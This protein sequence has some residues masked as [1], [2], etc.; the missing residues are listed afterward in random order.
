MKFTL[1][2]VVAIWV[3]V[4]VVIAGFAVLQVREE[5]ARLV[6]D[7]ERRAVLLGEG[8]KEAIEPV[9]GRGSATAVERILKKFGRPR[10]GIAVYDRFATLLVAT[11]DLKPVLP[12]SLPEVTEAIGDGAVRQ[13]LTSV[14]GRPAYV[15]ATPLFRDDKP[16]G[17][18][19]V[20]L[21]A[22]H[23]DDAEWAVGRQNAIRFLLL[24][25]VV[26]LITL[27]IV[28]TTVIQP[29]AKLSEW[30]QALRRGTPLPPPEAPDARLF[31]PLA[32]EVSS[33]AKSYYH[34][35]SAAEQEAALRLLGDT[36][37]TEERLKQFVRL[38]A[39]ERPLVVVSNREPLSHVRRNGR[40]EG[41]TPASGLV[42]AMGPVMRAC[43]GVWVAHGS[44]DADREMADARGRLG[45]P[46]DD[47][48]YTL[49]RVWLTPEEEAGYYY[50]FA[51]EGLWP[52]CHIV[53]TRPVFRPED[54]DHYV[55]VNRKFAAAVL[56]EV[57]GTEAPLV[58]VQD[59]HF[60]L[61]PGLVKA[62]RPD[63]RVA[64]FWH[65]PW[66][67][68]EAFGIC[69]WQRELLLGMLGADLIGFHTQYHC[70]NFLETVERTIEARIDWEHFSVLRGE[71]ETFV[72]PFPISV[73]PE[74]V[75]DPPAT[76][77]ADLLRE[78]GTSAEFLGVGVERV[79]YTKGLPERFRAL[80]WFF[81]R[82]PEYRER[83]VFVQLAAPSRSTIPRYQELQREVED[84]IREVNQ[85][86]QT[87]SWRP[88]IYLN[89]HHE[90]REIWAYYRHADFCMVTSLHDGM[91]LVAKEFVSVRDDDGGVLILSRFTGAARELRDAV[92][93]NP[94]DIAE[95]AEAIRAAVEMAPEERA[96]R[97]AR[98]RR[99]VR[100]HNIYQWAGLLLSELT[101]IP[102]EVAEAKDA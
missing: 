101:R 42:T 21:D 5:R 83:V 99:T 73:A 102:M 78:L 31:G 75:D 74:F 27:V 67:N 1:R 48:R 76:S 19:A 11:P 56:E 25:L 9:V 13:R 87:R 50:G 8:L 37:W 54:W 3:S 40:I 62:E 64:I 60:A 63:A 47:P 17:V 41:H 35:Q 61:L 71:H 28:R 92:L 77:R 57:E 2:L 70:N 23:V 95:T 39:G 85:A 86:L 16:A 52:L 79:D 84:T 90:H 59:Y 7:L 89:R 24:A 97:M 12:P 53:H 34:A 91:N 81:E 80:R 6:T 66:P 4:L 82:Y 96:A 93:V 32:H 72:K 30:T 44:G 55:G 65:I 68:F 18:L 43:G 38:R 14:G 20:V 33:L 22:A 69:P 94:Y 15:Y 10:R 29:M 46:E 51:N 45:L 58:L 88:I 100:E 98:M 36:V 26:S 49:R